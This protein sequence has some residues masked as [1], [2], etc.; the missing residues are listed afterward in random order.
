MEKKSGGNIFNKIL[1]GM[2]TQIQWKPL[3]V[4]LLGQMETDNINRMI[5]ISGYFYIVICIVN[6]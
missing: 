5:T 4:I 1:L 6:A 3:N 2:G